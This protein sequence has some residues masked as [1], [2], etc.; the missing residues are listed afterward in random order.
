MALQSPRST[1]HGPRSRQRPTMR[2]VSRDGACGPTFGFKFRV[3]CVLAYFYSTSLCT[4]FYHVK[5]T[6]QH[7]PCNMHIYLYTSHNRERR[8]T[9]SRFTYMKIARDRL[10][11]LRVRPL[12]E[13]D[14]LGAWRPAVWPWGFAPRLPA[15]QAASPGLPIQLLP[16]RPGSCAVRL[17]HR[18]EGSTR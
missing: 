10:H 6:M 9:G 2:R 8:T 12:F 17:A 14:L 11:A 4:A 1:H 5:L 15:R 18:F 3:R 7:S 16:P 13:G